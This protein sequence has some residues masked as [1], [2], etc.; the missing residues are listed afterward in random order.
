MSYLGRVEEGLRDGSVLD[1]ESGSES[2]SSGNS[3]EGRFT[4]RPEEAPADPECRGGQLRSRP[5]P[6]LRSS[7]GVIGPWPG[8]GRA[9]GND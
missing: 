6:P 2:V 8:I 5:S 3:P 9:G 1:F 4:E 7:E